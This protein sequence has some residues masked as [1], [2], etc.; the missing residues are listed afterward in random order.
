MKNTLLSG[1]LLAASLL[2]LTGCQW[3]RPSPSRPPDTVLARENADL[4]F[5]RKLLQQE[6][7]IVRR[8]QDALRRALEARAEP[9]RPP[10]ERETRLAAE[11]EATARELAELRA[12]YAQLSAGGE[13]GA[14]QRETEERL[15]AVLRD[16]TVLQEEN[17]RLR[18]EITAVRTENEQLARRALEAET[19][20][21]TLNLE[22][23]AQREALSNAQQQVG[24]L[25]SQLRAVIAAN[26]GAPRPADAREPAATGSAA[27][28]AATLSAKLNPDGTVTT[29]AEPT[30]PPAP[31]G[32]PRKHRVAAGDTLASIAFEYYG[33][34]ERWREIYAAN[35][36]VLR[37]NRPLSPGMELVIP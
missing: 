5:E 11:L 3:F 29:T 1:G 35:S 17:T 23:V 12:R 20:L 28:S 7:A 19:V 33:N 6:L 13:P 9:A 10:G 4:R 37:D 27:L 15:A 14:R 16:F 21:G 22:L 31:A 32:P 34:V 2:G 26:G 25:R 18:G 8:E 30:P 36:A 24:A